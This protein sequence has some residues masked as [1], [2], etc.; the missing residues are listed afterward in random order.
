MRSEHGLPETLEGLAAFDAV[1]LADFPA[2]AMSP[3]QM[4]M[5]KQYVTDLGGG[6][7]MFGSENG[8]GSAATTKRRSRTCCR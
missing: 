4:Q 6:L 7:V 3:R 8:F 2:T 5:I 1:V